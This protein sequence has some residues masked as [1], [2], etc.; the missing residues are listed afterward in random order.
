MV[1]KDIFG[2]E[3]LFPEHSFQ[4]ITKEIHNTLVQ[5]ELFT[6]S[7]MHQFRRKRGIWRHGDTFV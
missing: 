2:F 7:N 4:N 6:V 5:N 3:K 1:S